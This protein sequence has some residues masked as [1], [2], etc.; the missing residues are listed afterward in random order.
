MYLQKYLRSFFD[1]VSRKT[2]AALYA[3]GMLAVQQSDLWRFVARV[4]SD[5]EVVLELQK[6]RNALDA[7]CQC[8]AYTANGRC[9]HI[10]AAILAAE[11]QQALLGRM[12]VAITLSELPSLDVNLPTPTPPTRPAPPPAWQSLIQEVKQSYSPTLRS[13]DDWKPGTEIYYI[14]E[15]ESWHE[16]DQMWIALEVREPT[17]SGNPGRLKPHR[18]R[19]SQIPRIE[20]A[21]HREILTQIAGPDTNQE[22]AYDWLPLG[23]YVTPPFLDTLLPKIC[24]SG[25]CRFRSVRDASFDDTRIVLWEPATT[26]HFSATLAHHDEDY[27][28]QGQ[29]Q[30]DNETFPLTKPQCIFS[31]G[32]L[33]ANDTLAP[34]TP[35]S[36]LIWMKGLRRSGPMPI[37]AAQ[38][39]QFQ[40][41][42]LQSPAPPPLTWPEE[43]EVE[44]FH[45]A[46]E[47]C[48][49]F[50]TPTW[51]R[52]RSTLQGTLGFQY[53]SH[54][55]EWDNLSEGIFSQEERR[56]LHRDRPREETYRNR[57]IELG[58]KGSRAAYSLSSTTFEV[59]TKRLPAIVR[60]LAH[61]GWHVEAEGKL[62]RSSSQF[63]AELRSGV[64]WFELD[65]AIAY[66]EA[67]VQLP[68]LI[69]ALEKGDNL[70]RLDDG[71]YGMIPE[72]FLA[73]YG[74]LLKVGRVEDGTLRFSRAQTGLLDVFLAEREAEIQVDSVFA[75]ARAKIQSFSGIRPAPQPEGFLGE[76]REY[77]KE[78]LGWLYF[79]EECGWGGCL[80][81]DMGVGKT[82]QVLALLEK[83]RE[84]GQGPSLVVVPRSLV[85]NWIREAAR[86]CPQLKVLDHSGPGRVL[87]ED[88]FRTY[89]V[90]LMT[91]G[92]MRSDI[93]TLKGM[94]FDYAILD[95]AQAIKNPASE[96]AKAA[97]LLRATNRLAMSGTPI[98]NHLGELWSLFEFLNPGMLGGATPLVA[99][100]FRNPDLETRQLLARALRPFVLRR[101]KEQ[102]VQ[103]LPAKSESTIYCDLDTDQ[104]KLYDELR[105]YYRL[106]LLGKVTE[107]SLG[108]AKLQV[109]EALLRMRQAACHPGLID[110]TRHAESSAKFEVLVPMLEELLNEGHK[111]LVFSQFTSLLALLKLRLDKKN[112]T[113]EY[114]DGSTKDREARVERF[115]QDPDCKLFLIS[116]KAGGTG[117]NLTGADYVFLLDPWWNPAVEAQA[118]D[119]THRIGQTRPVFAYRLVARGTVEEKVLELQQSKRELADSILTEDNRLIG[120]LQREDLELLFG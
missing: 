60:A 63:H 57:L 74:M 105:D 4:A 13:D 112:L 111:A 99:D 58:L 44:D 119:R 106:N 103:E 12:G 55:F 46:P 40:R 104:R 19:R 96:S 101:T 31:N 79:L 6:K 52:D 49:R 78:G 100:L 20:E 85:Y 21:L 48:L 86:F 70:V 59:S 9:K 36:A 98:E 7:F 28:F 90:V 29:F 22:E 34:Y 88:I 107:K 24:D 53:S 56:F 68:A 5:Y 91:Y 2:G 117:L 113:Y 102:V 17:A 93:L 73:K 50:L 115:Q 30:V 15:P 94:Q 18:I 33:L 66:G 89:N 47:P 75:A 69:Q 120:N 81:D 108:K 77:Q 39:A 16:R 62:F 26:W 25:H 43:L 14:L 10:W 72:D 114:L 83:R 65:G 41:D 64:D 84:L 51:S 3:S 71:S 37:P 80:A 97:R 1:E 11:S 38:A 45:G 109:L 32:L 61:E 8:E 92:T 110:S 76:L 95:E 54:F 118:I 23:C 42:L 35:T 27:R 116:L 67:S 82:A 87:D